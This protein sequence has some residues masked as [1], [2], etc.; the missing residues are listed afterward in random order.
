MS[1]G[2]YF[3]KGRELFWS[4]PIASG[5]VVEIG[6]L[7]KNSSGKA[8]AMAT[9]SDNLNFIGPAKSAH[10]STDPS[11]TIQVWM[12]IPV[13][14]FEYP[15]NAATDVTIGDALQWN[16]AQKLKKSATTPIATAV[17]SKLQA[18][19]IRLVFRMPAATSTQIRLGT[20]DAS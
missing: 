14:I 10:K 12:P 3:R 9:T 13:M 8:A 2:F 7:L 11:T 19:T 4:W 16:A 1:D 5:T 15:L 17:E 18:T 20:G 6:D